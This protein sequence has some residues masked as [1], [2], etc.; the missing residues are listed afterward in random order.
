VDSLLATMVGDGKDETQ[1]IVHGIILSSPYI[2]F[3]NGAVTFALRVE[4][5][6]GDG[7]VSLTISIHVV[8]SNDPNSPAMGQVQIE[9][10]DV[11][12]LPLPKSVFLMALRS[13]AS[14]LTGPV[15]R[16]VT[17][18]AGS[19]TAG[20]VGPQ[21]VQD[22]QDMLNGKTF[23]MQLRMGSRT[24]TIERLEF[25]DSSTDAN[26]QPQPASMTMEFTPSS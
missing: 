2:R 12:M 26:G 4:N 10:L 21:I 13:Q 25:H 19:K 11:G 15:E 8:P 14:K 9:S 1:F 22:I 5:L 7:V 16:L 24:L 3:I 18:F 17:W 6:P 23:P 20:N